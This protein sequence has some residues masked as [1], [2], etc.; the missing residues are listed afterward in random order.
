MILKDKVAIITGAGS[1]IGRASAEIMAREGAT[2]V[3]LDRDESAGQQT[4]DRI[5]SDGGKADCIALDVTD[6]EALTKSI[7]DVHARYGRIDIL[8]NHAGAQVEG[9]LE[10]V[11]IEGFDR[12]WDLNVRSHFLAAR[13]VMPYM[14]QARC[15]VILNTSSSSGVLYDRE[16]IAYTTTK[17]AVIAMTRQMAGDYARHGIR[18]NALCPGWVDTPFNEPFIRQIGGRQ[19]IEAYINTKVPMGR[20]ADVQEIAEPILFLVSDRS[21]YITGQ[22]LVA[23]GGETIS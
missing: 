1:G 3:V 18:V 19:A 5:A 9:N 23:D 16:M 4:V 22:I 20:W 17:H 13:T 6:D 12:S 8:H 15:G 7:R 21:S 11:S 14:R 2:V 10:E